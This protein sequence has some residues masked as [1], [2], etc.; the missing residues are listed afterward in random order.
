MQLK[1]KQNVRAEVL[2]RPQKLDLEAVKIGERVELYRTPEK[3]D[4][5]GW[6]GLYDILDLG[7]NGA[8]V[9]WDGYP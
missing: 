3:K 6:R 4:Q 5:E 8:V 1:S 9:T 7:S 2:T